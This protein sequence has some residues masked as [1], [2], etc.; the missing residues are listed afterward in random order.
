MAPNCGAHGKPTVFRGKTQLDGLLCF[1][2]FS[3][4]KAQSRAAKEAPSRDAE[5]FPFFLRLNKPR[6]RVHPAFL[7][8][9]RPLVHTYASVDS[10]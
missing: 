7:L 2:T 5:G 1:Q 10:V 3:K 6:L 4:T 9:I 8:S